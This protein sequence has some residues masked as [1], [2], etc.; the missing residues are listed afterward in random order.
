[1][2]DVPRDVWLKARRDEEN[3]PWPMAWLRLKDQ[4]RDRRFVNIV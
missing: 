2:A 1:M 3:L 4:Y